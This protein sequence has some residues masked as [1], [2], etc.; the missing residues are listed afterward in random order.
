ML[1]RNSP[2]VSIGFFGAEFTGGKVSFDDAE[3]VGGKVSFDDTEYAHGCSI[4]WGPFEPP[5]AWTELQDR[6]RRLDERP[7]NSAV[8]SVVAS[9]VVA[10]RDV[11]D[12]VIRCG[13]LG[14]PLVAASTLKGE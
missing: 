6:E 13:L 11:N 9:V 5:A 3:Y 2:P 7:C 12:A 8:V 10:H 1:P 14:C 4:T